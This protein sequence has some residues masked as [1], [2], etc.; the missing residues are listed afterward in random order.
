MFVCVCVCVCVCVHKLCFSVVCV[1]VFVNVDVI[2]FGCVRR[3]KKSIVN[4]TAYHTLQYVLRSF[5]EHAPL[6]MFMSINPA[7]VI[8]FVPLFTSNFARSSRWL[9]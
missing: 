2:F 4:I 8:I 5:G 3:S 1:C 6:G 7:I 9:V